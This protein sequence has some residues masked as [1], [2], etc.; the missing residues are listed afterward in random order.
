MLRGL[1]RGD[2]VALRIACEACWRGVSVPSRGR[3]MVS[4]GWRLC[5][6]EFYHLIIVNPH[7]PL[8]W[9]LANSWGAAAILLALS[10]AV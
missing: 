3:E 2:G 1:V 4:D 6:Y 10:L 7:F 9:E 5:I 8:E